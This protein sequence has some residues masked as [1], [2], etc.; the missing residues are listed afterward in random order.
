MQKTVSLKLQDS[1][2]VLAKKPNPGQERFTK[3][4]HSLILTVKSFNDRNQ[5][6]NFLALRIFL[7]KFV[8]KQ[9]EMRR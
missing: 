1:V 6:I 3:R 4:I 8:P 5:W 2:L 7:S 9:P